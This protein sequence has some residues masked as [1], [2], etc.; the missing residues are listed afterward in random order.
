MNGTSS[1]IS[2][3]SVRSDVSSRSVYIRT[4][5]VPEDSQLPVQVNVNARRLDGP[6]PERID[7]DPP[8]RKLFLNSAVAEDQQPTSNWLQGGAILATTPNPR[9]RPTSFRRRACPGLDPGMRGT[10]LAPNVPGPHFEG[11]RGLLSSHSPLAGE[12]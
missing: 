4:A 12:G 9:K 1:A 2:T 6:L 8:L 3:T 11:W 7:H 10:G 5:R